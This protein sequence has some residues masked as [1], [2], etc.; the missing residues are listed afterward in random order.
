[1]SWIGDKRG[2]FEVLALAVLLVLAIVLLDQVSGV[3]Y[4][5]VAL[6]NLLAWIAAFIYVKLVKNNKL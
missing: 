4:R 5:A 6:I 2:F 3:V 1:M